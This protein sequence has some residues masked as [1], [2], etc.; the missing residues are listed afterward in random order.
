MTNP[1][2]TAAPAPVSYS[3]PKTNAKVLALLE[4]H[5]ARADRV[6]DIGAGEG[7][8]ARRVHDLIRSH[9]L[10]GKAGGMRSFSRQLPGPGGAVPRHQPAWRPAA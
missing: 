9:G 10:C 5:L 2:V 4:S 1:A 8:L 6:L 7:Y 3:L